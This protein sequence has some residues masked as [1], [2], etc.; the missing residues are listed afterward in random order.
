MPTCEGRRV[1][2]EETPFCRSRRG[3]V[4]KS[5]NLQRAEKRGDS[6]DRT[7]AA[8]A[9]SP[10][11]KHGVNARSPALGLG[12]S[13]LSEA[14]P[15]APP[16]FFT[17]S[18]SRRRHRPAFCDFLLSTPWCDRGGRRFARHEGQ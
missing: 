18:V 6:H 3:V 16:G 12:S 4:A 15:Y 1:A 9:I 5:S 11:L 10:A 8:R 14:Q 13:G 17:E 7:L 2:W